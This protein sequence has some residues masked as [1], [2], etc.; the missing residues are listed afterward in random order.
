M[1][2]DTNLLSLMTSGT[3]YVASSSESSRPFSPE[4][5]GISFHNFGNFGDEDHILRSS[6]PN[7][8]AR[9]EVG[10]CSVLSRVVR[11]VHDHF[12]FRSRRPRLRP[13]EYR[14][15]IQSILHMDP[16]I[17][18][19][20]GPRVAIPGYANLFEFTSD[21]EIRRIFGSEVGSALEGLLT[22]EGLGA[23]FTDYLMPRENLD[24]VRLRARSWVD[25]IRAGRMPMIG[26]IAQGFNG[27]AV[28]A[29]GYE[30]HGRVISFRVYNPNLP[31][32]VD[33]VDI[34]L[35]TGDARNYDVPP[36]GLR[37]LWR[38]NR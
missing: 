19:G 28:V 26:L 3:H 35:C 13:E 1:G 14:G 24:Q 34:D 25:N 27:H 15:F 37:E 12:Y 20:E 33:R 17:P 8:L 5:D 7:P 31:A 4:Y 2:S 10:Y 29:Y 21:P 23:S 22:L 11:V 9:F 16:R 18:I 36:R 6:P 32:K 30:V 38:Q